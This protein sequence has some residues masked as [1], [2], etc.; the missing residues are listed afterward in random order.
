MLWIETNIVINYFTNVFFNI[1]YTEN[2]FSAIKKV[3]ITY[4]INDI[5]PPRSES[6]DTTNCL[7]RPQLLTTQTSCHCH[8]TLKINFCVSVVLSIQVFC[9]LPFQVYNAALRHH[10]KEWIQTSEVSFIQFQHNAYQ[11]PFSLSWYFRVSILRKLGPLD[12]S[13]NGLFIVSLFCVWTLKF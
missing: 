7:K 6:W 13:T 2:Y 9:M 10:W 3:F 12:T 11:L 5:M 4:W 8:C 1:N